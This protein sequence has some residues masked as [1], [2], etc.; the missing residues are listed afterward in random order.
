MLTE[1]L[2]NKMPAVFQSGFIGLVVPLDQLASLVIQTL[3]FAIIGVLIFAVSFW[4]IV[5]VTPFSV[6]KEIE[7]DH[8]V[9]IAIV[10]GAVILGI[11]LVIAA[12]I[13]G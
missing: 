5:K 2:A 11:A 6:R 10:I 7:E 12:A 8:N 9:A 4:I 13:Q 1:P 3:V